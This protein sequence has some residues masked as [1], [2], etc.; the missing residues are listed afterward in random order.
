MAMS[1]TFRCRPIPPKEKGYAYCAG[2]Y[3]LAAVLPSATEDKDYGY[4]LSGAS[5]E[6][7]AQHAAKTPTT[8]LSASC[9]LRVFSMK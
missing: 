3:E 4:W 8:S 5:K 9:K 6:K 1:T 7:T 2:R